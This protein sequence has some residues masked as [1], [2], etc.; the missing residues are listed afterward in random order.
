MGGFFVKAYL[1][2]VQNSSFIPKEKEDLEMLMQTYLL[3]KSLYELNYNLNNGLDKVK[4][5][6][7]II[8]SIIG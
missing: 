5:P 4:A 6:I 8:K 3:E 2:K 1:E 7:R